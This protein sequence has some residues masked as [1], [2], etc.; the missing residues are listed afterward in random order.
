M[1]RIMKD[2]TEREIDLSHKV[3]VLM[4]AMRCVMNS[5][6][7]DTDA[8]SSLVKSVLLEALR[9]IEREPVR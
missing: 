4:R 8:K 2:M 3:T 7:S 9:Q 5:L 1:A 6:A